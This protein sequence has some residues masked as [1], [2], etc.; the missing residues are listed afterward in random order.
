MNLKPR[1]AYTA[2]EFEA[3]LGLQT[4]WAIARYLVQNFDPLMR[5]H[6]GGDWY[7]AALDFAKQVTGDAF[8]F[9]VMLTDRG[10]LCIPTMSLGRYNP[11]ENYWLGWA[12][13]TDRDKIRKKVY[14]LPCFGDLTPRIEEIIRAA[15]PTC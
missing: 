9:P 3:E 12:H 8:A 14:P 2:Q 11:S 1:N 6:V 15:T 4:G 13:I 5:K 7:S 10:T